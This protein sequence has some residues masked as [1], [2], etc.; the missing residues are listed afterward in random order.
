MTIDGFAQSQFLNG[1]GTFTA[2]ADIQADISASVTYDYTASDVP[3]PSTMALGGSALIG[4]AL[5]ARR[6]RS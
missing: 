5:M 6:K 2:F 3:E 1:G 4:L